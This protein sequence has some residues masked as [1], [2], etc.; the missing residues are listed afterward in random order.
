MKT[1]GE[2]QSIICTIQESEIT[3]QKQ[4][5]KINRLLNYWKKEAWN[6][7]IRSA[8]ENASTIDDPNCYCGNTGSEYP[9]DVIVDKE[10]ILKLL[11]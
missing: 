11:K 4:I 1:A 3:F 8:A 10:S 7:A 2:I 9:P 5:S 6:E